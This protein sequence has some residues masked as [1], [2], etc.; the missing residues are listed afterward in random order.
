M[1]IKI[2]VYSVLALFTG[3]VSQVQAQACC[4]GQPLPWYDIC[5]NDKPYL[6]IDTCC[7]TAQETAWQTTYNTCKSDAATVRTDAN[8]DELNAYTAVKNSLASAA[9][10]DCSIYF[11]TGSPAWVDCV[12]GIEDG[13]EATAYFAAWIAYTG[14]LAGTQLDYVNEL[15]ICKTHAGS[16]GII[17]ADGW[18]LSL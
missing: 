5:C 18:T 11:T 13:P 4:G 12:D 9:G 1:K 6:A 8:T 14:A 15:T 7:T 10:T 16:S 17:C 2:I 3:L